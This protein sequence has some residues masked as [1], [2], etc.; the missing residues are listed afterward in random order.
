MSIKTT[1]T[2]MQRSERD[3]GGA[4]LLCAL[5]LCEGSTGLPRTHVGGINDQAA[6]CTPH[7]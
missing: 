7:E 3:E 5:L 2:P 4:L 6:L 1:T